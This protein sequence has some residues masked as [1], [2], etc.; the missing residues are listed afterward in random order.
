MFRCLELDLTL[1]QACNIPRCLL[2]TA[3]FQCKR[4]ASSSHE[5]TAMACTSILSRN[6]KVTNSQ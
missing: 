2:L 5:D 1:E 6:E 4:A 3:V